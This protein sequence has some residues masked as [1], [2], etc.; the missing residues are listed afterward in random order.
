[1]CSPACWTAPGARGAASDDG[2]IAS[3]TNRT[4]NVVRIAGFLC[5]CN[6]SSIVKDDSE[7]GEDEAPGQ[8][9]Q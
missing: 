9:R 6:P 4:R 8:G 2:A 1:M 5:N 7:H 3:Y